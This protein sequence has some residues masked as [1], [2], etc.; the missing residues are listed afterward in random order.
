MTLPGFFRNQQ[1]YTDNKTF[2]IDI[3]RLF[4]YNGSWK[5][6]D[7]GPFRICKSKGGRTAF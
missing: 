2:P 1:F 7:S 6:P 5:I 4:D 3:V